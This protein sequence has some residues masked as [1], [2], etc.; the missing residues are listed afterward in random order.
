MLAVNHEPFERK[1]DLHNVKYELVGDVPLDSMEKRESSQVR[2]HSPIA[3]AQQV[4][5]YRMAMAAGQTFPPVV[6]W[7]NVIL[8]GNT[9]IAAA[10]KHGVTSLPAY[11]VSCRNERQALILAAALNQLNGRPLTDEEAREAAERMMD[12]GMKDEYIAREVQVNAA[13]VRRWRKERATNERA[14]RLG[15]ADEIAALSASQRQ[16]LAG[17]THERPFAEIAKAMADRQPSAE[18]FK[19][20]VADVQSAPSD[21]AAVEAITD[22]AADWEPAGKYPRGQAGH[23]TAKDANRSI[24]ALLKHDAAYYVDLA[25]TDEQLPKWEQLQLLAGQV[26]D[27]YRRLSRLAS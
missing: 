14:D 5:R 15:V 18:Q 16:K 20:L 11:R 17:I 23:S 13:K 25:L 3:P 7:G 27:E 1:F 12:D 4:E 24:G 21:D 9:R 6:L 26:I 10:R 19:Q 2:S 22:A 8:D